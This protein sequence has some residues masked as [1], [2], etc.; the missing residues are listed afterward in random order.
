MPSKKARRK[1]RERRHDDGYAKP[2]P[3][4]QDF[5]I[6]EPYEPPPLLVQDVSTQTAP[7]PPKAAEVAKLQQGCVI[8]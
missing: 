5:E 7:P 4:E 1:Q 8:C 2:L 3:Q 6:I